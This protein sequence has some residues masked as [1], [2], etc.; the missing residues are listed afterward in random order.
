MP[1]LTLQQIAEAAGGRLTGDGSLTV[2]RLSHPADIKAPQDLVLAMDPALLPLLKNNPPLAAVVSGKDEDS[3]FIK[4]RIFVERPR[5]A[6]AKLTALFAEPVF[7]KKGIH[8][9]AVI[10]EGVKIGKN[11]AVGAQVYIGAHAII[12]DDCTIHPQTYVGEKAEIGAN[13]LIYSG[14]RIGACTII[15]KNAIIH[16]NAS[17]GAD[18]FSFVTPQMGSVEAAK[19]GDNKTVTATNNQLIRIASLAPVILGDDIEIGANSCIDR[20]TIASTR[21]GNGTKIDNQVQIGHNVQIGENCMICGRVGIAGSAKIGHRVVL[22][23]AVGVADH[24]SV[25]DDTIVMAMSGI[26]GN[27]PPKSIMGGLPALPRERMMENIFNLGRLKQ[28]FKK[29]EHLAEK[30]DMLENL[31]KN[32]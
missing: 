13:T 19:A 15:G 12:G 21:I 32:D 26:A 30:I 23:G 9:S 10:E 22:G 4:N 27:V 11:V 31:S 3:S 7:V 8:P 16:F 20:G 6:I 24:V 18:G 29:I 17:I 25:G 28:F 14:T 2:T 1:L 5:L